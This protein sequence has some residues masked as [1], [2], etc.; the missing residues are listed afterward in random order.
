ME[1]AHGYHH[2]DFMVTPAL[3]TQEVHQHIYTPT[4]IESI[5]V[6]SGSN[7]GVISYCI[8]HTNTNAIIMEKGMTLS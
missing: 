8:Y 7:P 4:F 5:Q 2:S 1:S 3:G 6:Q